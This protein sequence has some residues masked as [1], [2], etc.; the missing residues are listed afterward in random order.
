LFS[1]INSY[2]TI[3]ECAWGKGW[4]KNWLYESELR[5][6]D[7]EE[8]EKKEDIIVWVAAYGRWRGRVRSEGGRVCRKEKRRTFGRWRGRS[9]R[10]SAKRRGRGICDVLCGGKEVEVQHILKCGIEELW[11][12]GEN[13]VGKKRKDRGRINSDVQIE[14]VCHWKGMNLKLLLKLTFL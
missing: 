7:E 11:K 6:D 5:D 3:R 2:L 10:E 4:T 9:G 12:D 13:M 8:Q 1:P 14:E